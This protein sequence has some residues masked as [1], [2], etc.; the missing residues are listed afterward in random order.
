[1]NGTNFIV[2]GSPTPYLFEVVVKGERERISEEYCSS[3][4]A[5]APFYL[6]INQSTKVS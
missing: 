3:L 6:I 5:W 2:L 1:M 4:A